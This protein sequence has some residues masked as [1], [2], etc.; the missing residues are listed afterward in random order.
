MDTSVKYHTVAEN[1]PRILSPSQHSSTK[2]NKLFLWRRLSKTEKE[3]E[4]NL[5][6]AKS[7]FSQSGGG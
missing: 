7:L 2:E 5:Q 6:M 3:Y 1:W 4:G